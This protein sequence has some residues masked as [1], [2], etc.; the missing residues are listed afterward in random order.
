MMNLVIVLGW[1]A[2]VSANSTELKLNSALKEAH[3]VASRVQ[4]VS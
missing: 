4:L 3:R 2:H 1:I